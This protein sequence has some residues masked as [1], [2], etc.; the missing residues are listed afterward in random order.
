M[1]VHSLKHFHLLEL[2]IEEPFDYPVSLP[3]NQDDTV[4]LDD[5]SSIHPDTPDTPWPI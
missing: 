2:S 1:Q 4:Y 5:H 3:Q